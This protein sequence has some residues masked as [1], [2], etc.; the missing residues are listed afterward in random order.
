M[1]AI[2]DLD[3]LTRSACEIRRISLSFVPIKWDRPVWSLASG[4]AEDLGGI[5]LR[6]IRKNDFPSRISQ[7]WVKPQDGFKFWTTLPRKETVAQQG[8]PMDLLL[9]CCGSKWFGR[10]PC[11][12][13][14]WCGFNLQAD[15]FHCGQK[16]MC[17]LRAY[18]CAASWKCF[19]FGSRKAVPALNTLV[20]WRQCGFAPNYSHP[21]SIGNVFRPLIPLFALFQRFW[22]REEFWKKLI[23]K[24]DGTTV[25]FKIMFFQRYSK[26]LKIQ[27]YLRFLRH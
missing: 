22:N 5:S 21:H 9:D 20:A 11:N 26:A 2:L 1:A 8:P 24:N 10:L 17:D 27:F 14:I 25:S 23:Q 7:P 6:W 4:V 19:A 16:Q 12:R 13:P 3:L 15:F 18:H